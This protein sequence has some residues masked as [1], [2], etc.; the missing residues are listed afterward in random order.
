MMKKILIVLAV[1]LAAAGIA[2]AVR[3]I[4][5]QETPESV[6]RRTFGEFA[7]SIRKSGNE[8]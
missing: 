7:E 6:I 8:V 1:I 5:F 3:L 4:F 2:V